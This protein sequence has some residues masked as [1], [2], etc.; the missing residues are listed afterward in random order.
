MLLLDALETNSDLVEDLTNEGWSGVRGWTCS[1]CWRVLFSRTRPLTGGGPS[2]RPRIWRPSC[3]PRWP[4]RVQPPRQ[5]QVG[6][7]TILLP[8]SVPPSSWPFNCGGE[9]GGGG[10]SDEGKIFANTL[11]DL[12]VRTGMPTRE[13]SIQ[14]APPP[15]MLDACVY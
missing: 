9:V 13:G 1:T 14:K 11:F 4:L 8:S 15:L 10:H 12:T 2:T 5:D 3:P 7:G 6:Q